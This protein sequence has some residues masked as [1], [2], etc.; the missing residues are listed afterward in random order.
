LFLDVVF[1]ESDLNQP[2]L[3]TKAFALIAPKQREE[4]KRKSKGRGKLVIF[5]Y[6]VVSAK[7]ISTCEFC[8]FK[9]CC[10]Y[11]GMLNFK[12]FVLFYFLD[13]SSSV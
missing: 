3:P 7:T 6:I 9:N 13:F 4:R 10:E 5:T 2:L 12:S 1:A 11:P 8:L